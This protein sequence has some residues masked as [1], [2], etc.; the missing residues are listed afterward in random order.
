MHPSGSLSVF[1]CFLSTSAPNPL[2]PCF[3]LFPSSQNLLFLMSNFDFIY[4]CLVMNL[5][6][7]SLFW[8]TSLA[9]C[10]VCPNLYCSVWLGRTLHKEKLPNLSNILVWSRSQCLAVHGACMSC[11]DRGVSGSSWFWFKHWMWLKVLK[12]SCISLIT[13]LTFRNG[14]CT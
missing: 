13:I 12:E 4:K 2:I 10:R 1:F 14:F 3:F 6:R 8:G 5:H 11:S 7:P 9:D